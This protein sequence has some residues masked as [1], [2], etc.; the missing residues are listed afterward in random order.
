MSGDA[1]LRAVLPAAPVSGSLAGWDVAL[2]CPNGDGSHDSGVGCAA[3]SRDPFEERPIIDGTEGRFEVLGWGSDPSSGASIVRLVL[4]KNSGQVEVG[5]EVIDATGTVLATPW[6]PVTFPVHLE[7]SWW[8]RSRTSGPGGLL[9]RSNDLLVG[10]LE[11]T[12]W[13]PIRD[14]SALVVNTQ[15]GSGGA[16]A[17]DDIGLSAGCDLAQFAAW[18]P[19]RLDGFEQGLGGWSNAPTTSAVLT[20][21]AAVHGGFGLLSAPADTNEPYVLDTGPAA[22]PH[23]RARFRVNTSSLTLGD[24]EAVTIL[25]LSGTDVPSPINT[26]VSLELVGDKN[27][28]KL[29]AT[30]VQSHGAGK[31]ESALYPVGRGT[32]IIELAWGADSNTGSNNPNGFLYLWVDGERAATMVGLRT[33]G[34]EVESVRMGTTS[35]S[36]GAAGNLSFDDFE[37]WRPASL[38]NSL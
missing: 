19:I 23:Y 2:Q 36:A 8:A 1:G 6:T 25:D 33:L 28:V 24:G 31:V 35:A 21:F 22:E 20:A 4:R 15:S 9:L 16:L 26:H 38:P 14:Q 30:Q 32:H 10:T 37:S 27:A 13:T 11:T 3:V 34:L 5:G 18:E 12:Y 29:K 7:L 17:L